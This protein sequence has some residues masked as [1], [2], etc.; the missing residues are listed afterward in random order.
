[1]D[2]SFSDSRNRNLCGEEP[3]VGVSLEPAQ[4]CR[5]VARAEG[6]HH[7]RPAV[8]HRHLS[9]LGHGRL[10]ACRAARAEQH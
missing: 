6:R 5:S 4:R 9:A 2:V 8:G 3:S 1:V 10:V 7:H